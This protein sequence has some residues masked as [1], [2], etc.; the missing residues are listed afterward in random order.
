M[1]SRAS[2]SSDLRMS[3]DRIMGQR[4]IHPRDDRL[5][6]PGRS[7]F[8]SPGVSRQSGDRHEVIKVVR[9]ENRTIAPPRGLSFGSASTPTTSRKA[10]R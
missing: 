10:A 9:R 8:A 7:H 5:H 1:K 2:K 6:H 4:D 3:L